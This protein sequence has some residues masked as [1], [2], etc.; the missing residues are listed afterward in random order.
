[1]VPVVSFT[2]Y[3]ALLI[4]PALTTVF[5]AKVA[6]N[7]LDY[8]LQSDAKYK[9]K[10]VVDSF[11]VRAGGVMSALVTALGATL[12]FATWMF[13]L[14]N[15]GLTLCWGTVLV[16]LTRRYQVLAEKAEGDKTDPAPTP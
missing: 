11:M 1:M 3:S 6:E 12:H 2:G 8:S 5:A 14:I 9:A 13:V 10:N 15:L 7:A 16:F 4:L